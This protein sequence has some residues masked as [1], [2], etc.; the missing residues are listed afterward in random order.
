[1]VLSGQPKSTQ[2][3]ARVIYPFQGFAFNRA[4]YTGEVAV[5]AALCFVGEDDP[6][7]TLPMI[8]H[9]REVWPCC[10]ELGESGLWHV[11]IACVREVILDVSSS[12]QVQCGMR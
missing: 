4:L 6:F 3:A 10:I 7:Q 9:P 2:F 12:F 1:V 8:S 5:A 11:P